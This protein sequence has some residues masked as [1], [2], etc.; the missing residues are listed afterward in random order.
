MSCNST[1]MSNQDSTVYWVNSYKVPCVGV[2]PMQCLQIQKADSPTGEWQNF[3]SNIEG[4]DYVPGFLYKLSVRET[5]LPP[6]QVPADASSLRYTLLEVL[7]KRRDLTLRLNDI[8]VLEAI[9]DQPVGSTVRSPYLELHIAQGRLLGHDGCNELS[10]TIEA[11]DETHLTF[12]SLSSTDMA[13]PGTDVPDRFQATLSAVRS[14][15]I[16]NGRLILLDDE[17]R[18]LLRFKKVD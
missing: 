10:G 11:V 6:E 14:Y 18:E 3:Y 16:G 4:F 1:K 9:S 15:T 2:G 17:G 13:C 12:R 5:K 8:W 7:E